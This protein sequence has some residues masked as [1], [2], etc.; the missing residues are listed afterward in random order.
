MKRNSPLL[1]L[2]ALLLLLAGCSSN[3]SLTVALTELGTATRTDK[4][5][6]GLRLMRVVN[7]TGLNSF[8]VVGAY[9]IDPDP[10]LFDI[11]PIL[12]S[13]SVPDTLTPHL[14]PGCS[15]IVETTYGKDANEQDVTHVGEKL[16]EV[17]EATL[18][19]VRARLKKEALDV[20]DAVYAKAKADNA[21]SA[22]LNQLLA[23]AKV[24][25]AAIGTMEGDAAKAD[26]LKSGIQR[27][28]DAVAAAD[29][30]LKSKRDELEKL[31]AK[32]GIVVTQWTRK[33]HLDAGASAAGAAEAGLAKES[34][35]TGHL[36]L[37]SPRTTTLYVGGEIFDLV[38][39]DTANDWTTR[40]KKSRLYVTQYALAAKHI[41]WTESRS[42]SLA[43][44]V[45]LEVNKLVAS[46]S[47][48]EV[49]GLKQ[50]LEA[51]K[52]K[53]GVGYESS[54]G[55]TNAGTL[56]G[57]APH[58]HKFP[59][60]PRDRYEKAFKDEVGRGSGYSVVYSARATLPGLAHHWRREG[61][62]GPLDCSTGK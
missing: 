29:G 16:V 26:S 31:I 9:S 56:S 44:R 24:L 28:K 14:T 2:P 19:A 35:T 38:N 4:G 52:L 1:C 61:G 5:S 18:L 25:D 8:D 47:G 46:L 17:N 59:L 21:D 53:V 10:P 3:P 50:G 45:A 54:Y 60:H 48:L 34:E 20:L 7:V 40:M 58:V 55:A 49:A 32:S 36:V 13:T 41:A 51:L 23:R 11:P 57:V 12:G 22:T 6:A 33:S 42:G 27:A 15:F 62:D 37:A 30:A 43:I 39:A